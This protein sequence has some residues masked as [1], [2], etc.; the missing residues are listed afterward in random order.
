MY[1]ELCWDY[2]L[3]RFEPEVV[4]DSHKDEDGKDHGV[5]A[6]EGAELE[7]RNCCLSTF[8]CFFKKKVFLPLPGSRA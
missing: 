8:V 3:W 1:L 2:E 6:Q 5:V 4:V 7:G